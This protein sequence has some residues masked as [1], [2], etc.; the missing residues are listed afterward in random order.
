[1]QALQALRQQEE[2]LQEVAQRARDCGLALQVQAQAQAQAQA[3]AL[4]LLLL[5]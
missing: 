4:L 2:A 5:L 1:V 3:L